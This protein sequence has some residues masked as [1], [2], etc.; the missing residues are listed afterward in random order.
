MTNEPVKESIE[1]EPILKM[2]TIESQLDK[3]RGQ[4]ENI[5][6]TAKMDP[7]SGISTQTFNTVSQIPN[8][9]SSI[10]AAAQNSINNF[11]LGANNAVESIGGM[12]GSNSGFDWSGPRHL[13]QHYADSNKS[14]AKAIGEFFSDMTAS[15]IGTAVGTMISPGLGTIGGAVVGFAVDTMVG[16][17]I[18][19]ARAIGQ[20]SDNI[21]DIG[22]YQSGIGVSE[23]YAD[24]L[25][26]NLYNKTESYEGWANH[27]SIDEF[28]NNI[29]TFASA[30][31]FTNIR[32]TGEFSQTINAIVEDT[33]ELSRTLGVFQDEVIRIMAD[34]KN[35]GIST[36]AD[37]KNLLLGVNAQSMASGV[38]TS[39]LI[40]SGI[41]AAQM[42][43][44]S[45]FN[46]TAAFNYGIDAVIETQ[47]LLNADEGLYTNSIIRQGGVQSA[48]RNLMNNLMSMN[49]RDAMM[50]FYNNQ[51]TGGIPSNQIDMLNG[52]ASF[53][54]EYGVEGL[55]AARGREGE[56]LGGINLVQQS[57]LQIQ[58]YLNYAQMLGMGQNGPISSDVVSGLIM[59]FNPGMTRDEANTIMGTALNGNQVSQFQQQYGA[60]VAQALQVTT[61]DIIDSISA[62]WGAVKFYNPFNQAALFIGNAFKET[63]GLVEKGFT[64][65]YDLLYGIERFNNNFTNFDFD[66]IR[67]GGIEDLQNEVN[68]SPGVNKSENNL[69]KVMSKLGGLDLD[70]LSGGMSWIS[71]DRNSA[72]LISKHFSGVSKDE[73]NGILK[74]SKNG[75]SRVENIK[76]AVG[77]LLRNKGVPEVDDGLITKA[78]TTNPTLY[79][80]VTSSNEYTEVSSALRD[81]KSSV[82]SGFDAVGRRSREQVYNSLS[83]KS[84][85]ELLNQI[86]KG[87]DLEFDTEKMQKEL[88]EDR[89]SDG[90]ITGGEVSET[91]QEFGFNED[92]IKLF[93]GSL[94][95][96][97]P[98]SAFNKSLA[99]GLYKNLRKDVKDRL[100]LDDFESTTLT[101]QMM[102]QFSKGAK[103][104]AYDSNLSK[105][106]DV[107]IDPN[108]LSNLIGTDKASAE[109]GQA[110]NMANYFNQRNI[111][112]KEVST[113][114][115]AQLEYYS[116]QK[117]AFINTK[118][119]M[120]IRTLALDRSYKFDK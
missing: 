101:L 15:S 81:Y 118:E 50:Y 41:N 28:R 109:L 37:S 42:L 46:Q 113:T 103:E 97:I 23:N 61:P 32:S 51:T 78:I 64:Q 93:M 100:N 76:D 30:G 99:S 20:L 116:L 49:S 111:N 114:E 68:D 86:K 57:Q 67:N 60:G 4:I 96:L 66:S 85:I 84:G 80:A 83:G 22:R 70:I 54:S 13:T 14:S 1:F 45:G 9:G 5:F 34:L 21:I 56:T 88:L 104:I 8:Y 72:N 63:G 48:S 43:S 39:T 31:G 33:R 98:E 25:A 119:G 47:N 62:G 107:K 82:V 58:K 38:D 2:D 16:S 112:L 102:T 11:S 10:V 44:S 69:R 90:I 55:L 19:R 27:L 3:V 110:I 94:D 74:Y 77:N 115:L 71:N 17:G 18:E 106:K 12:F 40:A 87:T 24:E 117:Q 7:L 36:V 108:D 91:L 53:M 95:T 120:A 35:K 92:K 65:T 75:N 26:K 79:N 59:N 29:N 89:Y 105:L 52:A 6:S 73:I